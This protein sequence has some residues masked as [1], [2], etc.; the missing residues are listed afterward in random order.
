MPQKLHEEYM[1]IYEGI[2][3]EIL[4]SNMFD[5]NSDIN[6][7]YLGITEIKNNQNKLKQRNYS[8]YL[9]MVTIDY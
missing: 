7:T 6:A 4:S 1:D 8:L 2:H 5:E 9:K 3:S